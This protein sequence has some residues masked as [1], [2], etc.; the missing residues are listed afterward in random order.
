MKRHWFALGYLEALEC[1]MLVRSGDDPS[2]TSSSANW[3]ESTTTRTA[4]THILRPIRVLS[5]S[6]EKGLDPPFRA[7]TLGT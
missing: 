1:G 4:S 5:A 2:T 7:E 3:G 6:W